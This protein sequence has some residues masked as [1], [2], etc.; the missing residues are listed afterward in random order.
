MTAMATVRSFH[1]SD[2]EALT[3]VF[4]SVNG[5][6]GTDGAFDDDLMRQM[7]SQPACD[8]ERNCYVAE[9]EG[10]TVGFSLVSAETAISR[11]VIN[12]G[13]LEPHRRQGIGRALLRRATARAEEL[14]ASVL[15][16]QVQ[17]G[18]DEAGPLLESEGFR[19]ARRYLN[20]TWHRA[21]LPLPEIGPEHLIRCFEDGDEQALTEL[22]NASFGGS[23]GFSPNTVEEIIAKLAFKTSF[24]CGVVFVADGRT[25]V[26]YNWT[27]RTVSPGG[28][29]G[30][31]G[32]TGVH[33]DYRRLGLGRA[34]LLAGMTYLVQNGVEMVRLEVD[35]LNAA[36]KQMY[37]LAGFRVTRES[38]WY[39]RSA[40]G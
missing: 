13:V 33:P 19:R 2:L 8:P 23:W 30:W 26:A 29:T 6:T 12:G 27:F 17:V 37:W 40:D 7:L 14:E 35:D 11:A 4:N 10:A 18:A 39:E 3:P 36:A 9:R 28:T 5:S 16:V 32:M 1:W 21:E 15:H 34:V 24:P 38:L 20:M 25:P 31:I 22:Q